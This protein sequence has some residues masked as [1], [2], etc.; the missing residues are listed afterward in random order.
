V[1][2]FSKPDED[3]AIVASQSHMWSK[4][5]AMVSPAIGLA[6][7]AGNSVDNALERS[8]LLRVAL[9]NLTLAA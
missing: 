9:N 1:A 6:G 4:I 8:G 5:S 7:K 3:M 2:Y